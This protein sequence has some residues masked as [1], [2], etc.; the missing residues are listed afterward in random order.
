MKF[1]NPTDCPYYLISRVSLLVTSALKKGFAAAG[2]DQ[3]KPAYIGV[4]WVLY[5]QDGLQAGELGRRAGLKPSTMTGL[6][7]RMERDGITR[8]QPDPNDRRAQRIFLTDEGTKM[9]DPVIQ[10]VNRVVN[11]IFGETNEEELAVTTRLLRKV[12]ANAQEGSPTS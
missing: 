6:L 5:Q 3:I 7:D 4:L 11:K 1:Q 9:R 10:T 2:A 12:L 8:R